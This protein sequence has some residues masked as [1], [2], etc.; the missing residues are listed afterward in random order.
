MREQKKV[1]K[2]FY[3]LPL[4]KV[5]NTQKQPYNAVIPSYIKHTKVVSEFMKAC[6]SLLNKKLSFS[7]IIL[8]LFFQIAQK[9]LKGFIF[10]KKKIRLLSNT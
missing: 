4:K 3:P 1:M 6:F 8:F 7:K 10:Q 9:I 2:A 5:E